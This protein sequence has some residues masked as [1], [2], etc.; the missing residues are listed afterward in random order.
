[1]KRI[2]KLT[3]EIKQIIIKEYEQDLIPT[4]VLADRYDVSR[5]AIYFVLVDACVDT[6]KR[7]LE[8]KCHYCG[9]VIKRTKGRIR[10]ANYLY[11]NKECYFGF[12]QTC[13]NK[14]YVPNRGGQMRARKLVKKYFELKKGYVVHHIDGDAGNSVID[15][16]MVFEGQGDHVRY[17]RGIDVLPIFDG[18]QMQDVRG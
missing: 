4:N 18:R 3:E 7:K 9:K 2:P 6:R 5:Q 12:V 16:L 8:V 11:C 14:K 13:G 10:N 1:M 15:N 17:H